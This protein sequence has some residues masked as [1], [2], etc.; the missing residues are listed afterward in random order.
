MALRMTHFPLEEGLHLEG[1][2]KGLFFNL[3]QFRLTWD[4]VVGT[5][6]SEEKVKNIHDSLAENA[7]SG[8]V[9][10]APVL[11]SLDCIG[12]RIQQIKSFL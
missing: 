4:E 10:Y 11:N 3:K 2:M 12:E 6:L 9:V 5:K 7:F 1:M 8:R